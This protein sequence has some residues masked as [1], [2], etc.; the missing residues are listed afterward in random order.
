MN[1][2]GTD[3]IDQFY[4]NNGAD[5][6]GN[7]LGYETQT[8]MS[9][10]DVFND[11]LITRSAMGISIS[12]VDN[13]GDFDIYISDNPESGISG[14]DASSDLFINQLAQTGVLSFEHGLVDTGLSWGVQIQDFDNDG[15]VE[16]H[17]TN[18]TDAHSGYAALLEIVDLENPL[19]AKTAADS[20]NPLFQGRNANT[21][22]VGDII[23]NVVDIAV[24]SGT[25]NFQA[26]GRGNLAA[27]FNRDGLVDMF[28][29]NLNN[30]V[31]NGMVL[32]DPSQLLLNITDNDNN[33][34]NIKLTGDPDD[35]SPDGYATS[36]DA[37]GSRVVVIADV[38]GDGIPEQQMREV[39]SSTGNSASTSSLDLSFGLGLATEADVTVTWA[40]G[41]TLDM[42]TVDANQFV[43]V[44]QG[45]VLGDINDDG[46]VNLLDVGPFVDLLS[47]GGFDPAADINGDG[48]VNLLDVGP[49]IDLLSG[50]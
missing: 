42:G 49:F 48:V 12:D 32:D 47:G 31:R 26:N 7:W 38:D 24:E 25:G 9:N 28:I 18:D 50:G 19:R 40:D 16:I 4:I 27:D 8:F 3:N 17:T 30:D 2:S 5:A 43:V 33:F 15:D 22:P 6:N 35:V 1:A 13:D 34:L 10:L 36:L 45:F 23:A 29:V 37:I 21:I 39:R 46:V 44:S 14:I 11:N 41:R 20:S